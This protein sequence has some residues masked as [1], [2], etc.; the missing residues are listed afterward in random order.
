MPCCQEHRSTF[1]SGGWN[2]W[3]A[4]TG[5]WKWRSG[6]QLVKNFHSRA[7]ENKKGPSLN[8]KMHP[9]LDRVGYLLY[10]SKRLG[11]RNHQLLLWRACCTPEEKLSCCG[12]SKGLGSISSSVPHRVLLSILSEYD[13]QEEQYCREIKR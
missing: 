4:P 6:A 11:S 12:F 13:S 8:I 3:K 1:L 10:T 5:A 7:L 9:I 2:E